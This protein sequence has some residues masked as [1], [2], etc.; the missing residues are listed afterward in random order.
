M[1][2]LTPI[3]FTA[4]PRPVNIN[5]SHALLRIKQTCALIKR[6]RR[7]T[8]QDSRVSECVRVRA[9]VR[10]SSA[11]VDA[12]LILIRLKFIETFNLLRS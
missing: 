9:C 11:Y 4:I 2:T 6:R 3:N 1:H 10:L 8:F 12:A 5:Y 7:L